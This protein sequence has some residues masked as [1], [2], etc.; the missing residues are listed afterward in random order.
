MQRL[1]WIVGFVL[2]AP[3]VIAAAFILLLTT[4]TPT[5]DPKPTPQ[6]QVLGKSTSIL[7]SKQDLVPNL[8]LSITSQSFIGE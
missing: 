4:K 1:W 5:P 3:M 7:E 6:A 2:G 8:H